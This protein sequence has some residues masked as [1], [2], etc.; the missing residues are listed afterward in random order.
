ML[1]G[2]RRALAWVGTAVTAVPD[3][4]SPMN[5]PLTASSSRR[6][7][8]A[9]V[10]A[11]V[12]AALLLSGCSGDAEPAPAATPTATP[13]ETVTPTSTPTPSATPLSSFED[14]PQVKVIRRWAAAAAADLSNSDREMTAS[15]VFLTEGAVPRFRK[16]VMGED[17]DKDYPG[18]IPF[19]PVA[20]KVKGKSAQVFACLQAEGWGLNRKTGRPAEKRRIMGAEFDLVQSK[21]HWTIDHLYDVTGSV[22][23][24]GV[25]VEGVRS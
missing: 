15:R 5:E 22:D 10:A 9:L 13:S 20:V 7:L 12:A 11:P 16:D 18:P 21:G 8:A 14:R 17:F 23:C 24:K 6:T 2:F 4:M 3:P 1:A 19:T 25:K